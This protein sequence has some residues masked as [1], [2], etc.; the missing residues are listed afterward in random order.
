MRVVLMLVAAL[1]LGPMA[2]PVAAEKAGTLLTSC[3]ALIREL[4]QTGDKVTLVNDGLLCWHYLS[5]FQDLATVY[6]DP[7]SRRSL[8][9]VCAPPE[10][11]LTQFVRIFVAF[12]NRHP[13]LLHEPAGLVAL[14]ALREA[15]P[16]QS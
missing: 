8:L 10:S 6:D 4:R 5:A 7:S 1:A 11:R 15:F 16:C 2:T 14:R 3:E 12:A 9:S 13:E